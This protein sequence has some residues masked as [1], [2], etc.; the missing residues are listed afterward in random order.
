MCR[1]KDEARLPIGRRDDNPILDST[2][3]NIEFLDGSTD[4]VTAN[5][6]AENLFSKDNNSGS[7]KRYL[8]ADSRTMQSSQPMGSC[9]HRTAN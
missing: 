5:L 7:W 8:I 6:I 1:H 2:M 3:Y 9:D 4:V